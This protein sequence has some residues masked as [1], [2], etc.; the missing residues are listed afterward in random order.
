MKW[1]TPNLINVNGQESSS[2]SN[3]GNFS[4]CQNGSSAGH[5]CVSGKNAGH[6]NGCVTG[7]R[8]DR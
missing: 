2:N 5:G 3:A 7:S 4:T 8:V 1:E 6:Y